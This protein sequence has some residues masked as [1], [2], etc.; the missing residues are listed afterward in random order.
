MWF[1]LLAAREKRSSDKG[2]RAFLQLP[3]TILKTGSSNG[4]IT[5]DSFTRKYGFSLLTKSCG[6]YQWRYSWQGRGQFY[7]CVNIIAQAVP[8]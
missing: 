4:K 3:K 1:W 2:Y 8:I 5:N 6:S 7:H